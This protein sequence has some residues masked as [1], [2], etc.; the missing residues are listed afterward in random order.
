MGWTVLL[1]ISDETVALSRH[2][3]RRVELASEVALERLPFSGT[4]AP[5]QAVVLSSF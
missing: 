1:N 3:G 4:L 5:G 2:E